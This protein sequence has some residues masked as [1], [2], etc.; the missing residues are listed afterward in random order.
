VASGQ[1]SLA[2][3]SCGRRA[4]RRT[5]G[6]G[7][8]VNLVKL[9]E[10]PPLVLISMRYETQPLRRPLQGC[11]ILAA[12]GRGPSG[13]VGLAR[14]LMR[15]AQRGEPPPRT[16]AWARTGA[17]R[18]V[19]WARTGAARTDATAAAA[20]GGAPAAGACEKQSVDITTRT[21]HSEARIASGAGCGVDGPAPTAG[22][23]PAAGPAA[24]R[25]APA[26]P[27]AAASRRAASRPRPAGR[28]RACPPG[29][30]PRAAGRR[31]APRAPA[32]R[33]APCAPPR[34]LKFTGLTQ[35]LVQP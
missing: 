23:S 6:T 25:A 21:A 18:T 12:T 34:N 17:A 15:P 5:P 4:R 28:R 33:R 19:V 16:V 10:K 20:L 27:G 3:C 26:A 13:R 2:W 35:N 9:A 32:R 22:P 7:Q 31:A 14:G 1:P 24:A 8:R 29:P 30:G 11:I